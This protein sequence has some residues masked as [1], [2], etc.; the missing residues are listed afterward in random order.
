MRGVR[1]ELTLVK[2]YIFILAKSMKTIDYSVVDAARP[3]NCVLFPGALGD[4]ICFLP[5]LQALVADAEV[6]LFARSEFVEIIPKGVTVT[7][8]ERYEINRLFATDSGDDGRL[9]KIFATYQTI[10]S[11][12][13]SQ[14]ELFVDRLQ[15]FSGGRAKIFPFRSTSAKDHQIDYYLRCLNRPVADS[16]QPEISLRAEAIRWCDDFWARNSLHASPVLVIAPGSGAREKNW[17]ENY[18]LSVIDWWRETTTGVAVLLL[19][20]VEA[21]RGGVERLQ[22]S[23]DVIASGLTLARAAALLRRCDLFLGNDS[24]ISHLAAAVGARTIV[25]FGP[26][27][28]R[29][30]APRGE[31]VTIV[32]RAIECSP[33]ESQAMKICSHRACLTGLPPAEV[34]NRMATQAE[35]VTLTRVGAGI[36]V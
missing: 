30:W 29:Q 16:T 24:G 33:C 6:D 17:P 27:D 28:P 10:Y 34:I 32:S 13:G 12:T 20:P 35:A 18:F 31:A 21:E 22:E 9:R 26:S 15:S 11:W 8:L 23:A 3:R 4:F 1:F 36:K 5:A 14:N 2:C 25:L 19:G 7:S